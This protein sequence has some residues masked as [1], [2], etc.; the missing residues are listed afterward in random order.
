MA[1]DTP[2]LSIIIPA[3]DEAGRIAPYLAS[4]SEYGIGRGLSYEVL[5]VDDGSRDETAAVVE[6]YAKHDPSV[7]IIRLTP[8]RGKGAAV[9]AGMHAARGALHLLADADGAT[10]IAEI[11]RLEHAIA[12]GADLAIGSRLLASRNPQFHVQARWHR[13]VL[14]G[15]FNR[16]VQRLGLAGIEDTQCGFKLFRAAVSRDLFSLSRVDGY[17]FDLEIL[18]LA[19]RRGYRIAEVPVNWTDQP[20]S[21]VRVLRDGFRMLRDLLLVRR[22]ER[23]GSYAPGT[24]A[25]MRR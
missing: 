10:P 8:N 3:F 16:V 12:A 4:I 14:G 20:G 25:P 15:L 21:K 19:K 5:V 6:A 23:R 22:D 7:Q 24:V 13:S 18:Y 11:D 9:R 1:A 2:T 17:G